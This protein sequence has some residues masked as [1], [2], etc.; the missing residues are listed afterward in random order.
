MKVGNRYLVTRFLSGITELRCI[1]ETKSSYKIQFENGSTLW[2]T[3]QSVEYW[4]FVEDLGSSK[5]LNED[6]N[7]RREEGEIKP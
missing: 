6:K 4:N 5:F 1:E 3:K 2:E 7:P